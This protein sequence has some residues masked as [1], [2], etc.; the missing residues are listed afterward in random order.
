MVVEELDANFPSSARFKVTVVT[1][2]EQKGRRGGDKLLL[3]GVEE[4]AA[5]VRPTVICL[6]LFFVGFIPPVS[7][8][9][10]F[11][12]C[13]VAFPVSSLLLIFVVVFFGGRERLEAVALDEPR[14][15]LHVASSTVV[16][17]GRGLVIVVAVARWC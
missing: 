6:P 1:F 15:Q 14:G 17:G 5:A 11:F 10:P 13:F 9:V 4:A 7:V 8:L 12:R 3:E 16:V 2:E